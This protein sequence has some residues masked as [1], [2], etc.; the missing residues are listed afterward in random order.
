MLIIVT[1]PDALTRPVHDRMP[2][3]LEPADFKAWLC[4]NDGTA[5]DKPCIWPVSR[6]VNKIGSGDD[7][8]TLIEEVAA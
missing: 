1:N 8:P 3:I 2:V 6:R 4:G 5:D 7:N